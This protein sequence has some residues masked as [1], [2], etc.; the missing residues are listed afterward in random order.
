VLT[1]LAGF[2]SLDGVRGLTISNDYVR[3]F[4]DVTLKNTPLSTLKELST[5]YSEVIGDHDGSTSANAKSN[6]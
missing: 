4:F 6:R 1:R 2:G 3:T 5:R